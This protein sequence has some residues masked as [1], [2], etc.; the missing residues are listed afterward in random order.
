MQCAESMRVQAYFD[1]EVDALAA[2]DIERHI[3][4]CSACGITCDTT[5]SSGARRSCKT[6]SAHARSCVGT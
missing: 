3:D 4:S 2:A 1:G 5:H 6:L